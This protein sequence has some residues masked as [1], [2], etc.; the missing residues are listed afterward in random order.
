M[1]ATK[2]YYRYVKASIEAGADLIISGAGLPVDLPEYVK[3][4]K[5]KIAPIISTKKSAQVL[6]KLWARK[7][8]R[9]PDLLIIEGPEAGG[10]LGFKKEE[11]TQ[12]L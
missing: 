1:T 2:E 4:S 7:Y 11:I 5:T 10:H 12:I 8:N 6:L 3:E 9:I